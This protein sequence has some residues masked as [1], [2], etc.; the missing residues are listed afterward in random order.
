MLLMGL[1]AMNTH[2]S[3]LPEMDSALHL[4]IQVEID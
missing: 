2:V 4:S 1:W 3:A